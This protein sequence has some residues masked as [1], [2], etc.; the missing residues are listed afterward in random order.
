MTRF[1]LQ[2]TPLSPDVC[3]RALDARDPRFDGL[4]FV[5]I[6]TTRI[7]CRP[8]CPARVSHTNRRRYF[9][10]A[11]AAERAGFRPCLRCRP[12][13]A[14]GRAPVDAVS[15]LV[16]AAT[17]RIEAGALNGHSVDEL[18]TE[19]GVSGRHLRRV[20][21]REFGVSPG[22]LA[23]THRL[24][25]AKRLL[26]D[27]CLPI[28]RV[29]F[30]SGFQSL[31]RFNA[32]FREQYRMSPTALRRT[33]VGASPVRGGRAGPDAERDTLRLTLAYR[34]PFDW[35]G[36]LVSLAQDAMPGVECIDGHRYWRTVALDGRVGVVQVEDAGIAE[37]AVRRPRQSSSHTHLNVELSSSLVP[38]IM[39]LIT[40]LRRLFDLDAE[41]LLIDA[42]LSATGLASLVRRRPGVRIPGSLDPFDAIVGRLSR[43][44]ARSIAE[45]DET[46]RRVVATLGEPV[47]TGH[48][49]LT[50]VAPV[51]ARIA[52]AGAVGLLALGMQRRAADTLAAVATAV[53]DGSLRLAA[54]HDVNATYDALVDLGVAS[55]RAT[56]IVQRALYWPDA[57]PASD[58]SL[59]RAARAA[60]ARTLARRA[61]R[62]RPWRA[63]A[64]THLWLA[65]M[66]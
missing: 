4:F 5:G 49:A 59:L 27:T 62:W 19:L 44:G 50:H 26:A 34:A 20:L 54:G 56:M 63:Y 64:A 43:S 53:A 57:F 14:P 29:A 38:V 36:L 35:S 13:L 41:P 21:E 42:H 1:R 11:G 66:R 23:Q 25:L 2:T 16:K 18:A 31:R 45:G 58:R 15:R 9:D 61:E 40:R 55:S 12:E 24:L 7:Y 46:A 48:V 32:A 51:A 22:E 17:S 39:T 33:P 3:E 30:A 52:E 8:V 47:E 10:T 60:G 6:T 28:T 37:S 65:V